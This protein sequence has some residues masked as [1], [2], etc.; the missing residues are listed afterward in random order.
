MRDKLLFTASTCSHILHFHLPYLEY[1]Q[2]QGWEVHVACG[3]P[4]RPVPYADEVL[5][6]PFRKSMKSPRNFRAASLLREKIKKERYKLVST[7]TSLAAF[8]TRL[9]L[10]GLR[11]RPFVVNTVHGYLF[12]DRTPPLQRELLLSAE[13]WTAPQTDLLLTMNQWDYETAVRYRL[14]REVIPIPGVGVDFSKLDGPPVSD[15]NLRMEYGISDHAFLLLYAAE[16]S[17][18]KNQE[19]LIRAMER[20]PEEIVLVLAGDGALREDC[21]KLAHSLNLEHRII[22]PGYAENMPGWYRTADAVVSASRSEGLP[23][24]IMEAMYMGLPVVVSDV[25]GHT[26]LVRDGVTGLLYPYG[27]SAACAG[28]IM[29]LI[30]SPELR[31]Q[32]GEYARQEAKQ[33]DLDRV[34]PVTTEVYESVLNSAAAVGQI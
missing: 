19:V 31:K 25:K 2:K 34:R 17:K 26:D 32:L 12:D 1:F 10:A 4:V 18:R 33:Y 28:Q 7:H 13:R 22:F 30:E 16:F 6:L 24:H 27:D 29:R 15:Q 14:G 21:R 5:E 9:A 20:L 3:G 11:N 8:F 23:F